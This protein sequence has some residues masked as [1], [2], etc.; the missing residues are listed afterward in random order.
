MIQQ[1]DELPVLKHGRYVDNADQQ[2]HKEDRWSGSRFTSS[3]CGCR[4]VEITV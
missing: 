2:Q 4:C 3:H 1:L